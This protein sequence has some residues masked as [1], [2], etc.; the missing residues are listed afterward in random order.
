MS[1]VQPCFRST[2]RR[3]GPGGLCKTA[4]AATGL[5][6]PRACKLAS[7]TSTIA[8]G[9]S[10]RF[11]VISNTK[12]GTF[13]TYRATAYCRVMSACIRTNMHQTYKELPV[14]EPGARLERRRQVYFTHQTAARYRTWRCIRLG[15]GPYRILDVAYVPV[16]DGVPILGRQSIRVA[17]QLDVRRGGRREDIQGLSIRAGNEQ[18]ERKRCAT[19]VYKLE[20]EPRS[21]KNSSSEK[22]ELTGFARES[23]AMSAGSRRCRNEGRLGT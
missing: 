23:W 22:L 14:R 3:Q 15:G 7:P 4:L 13:G 18:R 2:S 16:R 12:S 8:I 19:S 9:A 1:T 20:T 17:Y 5:G 10:D 11:P 21:L 6:I